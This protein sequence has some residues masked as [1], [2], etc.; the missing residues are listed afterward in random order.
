MSTPTNHRFFFIAH[1][2]VDMFIASKLFPF[3]R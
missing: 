2:A 3:C 1:I